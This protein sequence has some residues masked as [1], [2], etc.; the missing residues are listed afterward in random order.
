VPEA[1]DDYVH[2]IGRT[3]RAG[4]TGEAYQFVSKDEERHLAQIER[5]VGQR[6]ARVTLPNFDYK[7]APPE[8]PAG[9]GAP[10][11]PGSRGHVRSGRR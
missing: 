6:I 7:Q 10:Q 2:R 1:P 11:R 5:Q 3:G 9:S 8:L 4:T